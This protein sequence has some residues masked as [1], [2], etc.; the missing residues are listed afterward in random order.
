M[1]LGQC[2]ERAWQLFKDNAAPFVLG[3]LVIFV[4]NAI[5]SFLGTKVMGIQLLG[6][7]VS[8]ILYGGLAVM[9][10]KA[11]QGQPI[12]V[13]EIFAGF[14]R[15]IPY[16]V[17]GLAVAAGLIA[18]IVGVLATAFLFMFAIIYVAR[19]DDFGSALKASYRVVT[20]NV[21]DTAVLFVVVILL[22]IAGAIPLGLGLLVTIPLTILMLI[23]ALNQLERA[24]GAGMAPTV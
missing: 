17:V 6:S 1:Q 23:E 24:P 15:P 10:L 9:A 14:Q 7:L 19:G 18:C 2:F 12:D 5:F 3:A 13:P 8:S 4:T 21:G 22:N 20:A 16:I 11:S